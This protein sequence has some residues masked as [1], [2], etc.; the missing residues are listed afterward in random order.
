MVEPRIVRRNNLTQFG[1]RTTQSNLQQNK[2]VTH[3]MHTHRNFFGLACRTVAFTFLATGTAT[4]LHAQQAP[5]AE[6]ASTAPTLLALSAAAPN[7]TA[8][9]AYSSSSNT[10]DNFAADHFFDLKAAGESTQPPPRRRYGRPSYSDSHTNADGSNKYSFLGGFGLG[11]PVGNTHKY[12]T[13]SWGFQIGGGRN[14]SKTFGVMLQFDYDHFGL[15]GATI[16]NEQNLYNII[17]SCSPSQAAAGNCS[18]TTGL[19][20]NNHIWSFTLNPTFT[21]PTEGALGA[22]AVVGAGFYHKVTNFTLPTVASGF[23][24]FYGPYQYIAN[25]NIDH[26]T[27]NA[28]GVNAGVGATYKFSHFSSAKFY[29]EA[30]YVLVLNPQRYGYTMANVNNPNLNYPYWADYPQNSNRT[31]YIPITFGLRF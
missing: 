24:Y 21:L 31:T 1:L 23:D 12:E 27:S 20:G 26:Y 17:Y 30:R 8:P 14:F 18:P 4:L 5:S 2:G 25:Q 10:G 11:L 13:P 9:A 19:D 16:A 15:Q 28:F 7:L 22:Y 29:V 6:P 3:T